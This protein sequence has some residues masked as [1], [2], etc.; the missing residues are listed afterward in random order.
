MIRTPLRLRKWMSTSR[1]G[2]A[3]E[4]EI[5]EQLLMEHRE[6]IISLFDTVKNVWGIEFLT[7][8]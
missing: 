7:V 4:I 2:P 5:I 1:A 3:D 8:N 6:E